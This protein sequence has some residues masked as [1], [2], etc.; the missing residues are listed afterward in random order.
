MAPAEESSCIVHDVVIVGAGPSGLAV[1]A[2]LCEHTPS[3]IFTDE[4][5]RRYHWI[6]KHT[7][8]ATIKNRKT[9][10]SNAPKASPGSCR[11][12]TTL[13]LDGSGDK[14]MTKWDRLFKTFHISHLRSP[15]FFHP[16]PQDRD[17]L[18]AFAHEERRVHELVEI[19][20]CVGKEI[21]KH[22]KKQ[23]KKVTCS[24]CR[25]KPQVTIDERDRRDYYAPSCSLFK[26][27]CDCIVNRYDLGTN[28]ISQETLQDIDFGTVP[29]ITADDDLFT[30]KTD[31]GIHFARTVVLAVGSGNT[32]SMPE[33]LVASAVPGACHAMHITQFPDPSVAAKTS[34]RMATNVMVVG[35]G[36]TSAQVTTMAVDHER[37]SQIKNARGGGSITPR[38]HKILKQHIAAGKVSMHQLTSITAQ[39]YCPVKQ[40][41]TVNTEP[42]IPHLPDIDYIYFATGV[43]SDF[44][45]LPFLQTLCAKC[46]ID[47]YGGLPALNDDLMWRDN[48]PL[49]VTGRFAAL[50]LGPGA[51]NLEGA[52][53]GAERVAWAIEEILSG[54]NCRYSEDR[55]AMDE[56]YRYNA[57]IGS[58]FDSLVE[59]SA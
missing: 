47:S 32:P 42:Q 5:H 11:S 35:G 9:G 44:R 16:D 31:K 49:F 25:A 27:Y 8:R 29:Q 3:A 17:G 46:P 59:G 4:E 21:S 58:R 22:K 24:S 56:S 18:L 26:D 2:R 6:Q 57:G 33:N 53:V 45:T 51:G 7:A 28:V 15:L 1:A 41:W 30:L 52:R 38:Y 23:K 43:E 19:P 20:E 37:L 36:L 10:H 14:W 40:S 34:M 48:I 13:V 39:T 12:F 50:R 54:Q 55:Q